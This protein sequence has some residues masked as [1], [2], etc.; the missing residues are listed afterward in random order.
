[1]NGERFQRLH[2]QACRILHGLKQTCQF[3]ESDLDDLG[4]EMA[5]AL[6][7]IEGGTDSYCLAG[8]VWAA[9]DWLRSVYGRQMLYGVSQMPDLVPLIDSGKWRRVWC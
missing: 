9:L 5:V 6:L 8:A 4:Q 3:P 2:E 1:M 7:E